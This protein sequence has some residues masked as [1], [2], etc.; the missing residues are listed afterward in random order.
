VT[1]QLFF[2]LLVNGLSIGLLYALV[3]LGLVLVLGVAKVFNFAHGEFFMVGAYALYTFNV[4]LHLNFIGSIVMAGL[5]VAL[6]GA[7][8]NKT[9]FQ[10]VSGSILKAAATTIGLGMI[11]QQ[12][13]L[14]LYG[15]AERG[16]RPILPGF[17]AVGGVRISLE[18]L[19]VVGCCLLLV[20]FL[21]WFLNRT[22]VGIAMRATNLDEETATLQGINSR[23]MY[24]VAIV[25]GSGLAGIA[26]GIVAPIRALNTEMGHTMLFYVLMVL[27]LGGMQSAIGAVFGGLLLG[28][29]LSFGFHFLGGISE[30]LVFFLIGVFV[31][32]KPH[33]LFGRAV[34]VQ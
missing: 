34:D 2:Q 5:T 3:A 21:G 33:G 10:I 20:G 12:A 18:R 19:V 16:V 32:F 29:I 1:L 11:L 30:L 24:L 6:L 9:I 28:I 26:G 7:L 23:R 25:V 22:K 31:M 4:S 17:I 8:C 15:T 27:V 14:Q 13:V